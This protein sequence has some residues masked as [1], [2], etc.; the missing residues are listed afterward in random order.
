MAERGSEEELK[1][2]LMRVGKE[3]EKK[4]WLKIQHSKNEDHGFWS[5]HLMLNRWGKS[6]DNDRFYFLGFQKHCE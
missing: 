6:E 4:I 1:S 2:L 3:V 5:H